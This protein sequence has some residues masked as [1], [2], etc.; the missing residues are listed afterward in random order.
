MVQE[1][2]GFLNQQKLSQRCCKS[3]LKLGI[4]IDRALQR[5]SPKW[6][7]NLHV[8]LERQ[9]PGSWLRPLAELKDCTRN[10]YN[11]RLFPTVVAVPWLCYTARIE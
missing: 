9:A 6:V 11:P 10:F 7:R 5:R 4:Y 8:L 3:N 2:R 1:L